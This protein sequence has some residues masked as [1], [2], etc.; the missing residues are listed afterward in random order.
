MGRELS[1]GIIGDFDPNK[2]YH[3]ATNDALKHAADYLSVKASII[4]LPTNS[5]LTPESLRKV[6]IFDEL[7]AAPGSPYESFEGA[8]GGIKRARLLDKPFFGT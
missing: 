5:L 8:I 4:W 3:K 6:D 7:M 1:V 2:V